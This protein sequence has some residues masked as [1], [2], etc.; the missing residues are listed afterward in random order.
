MMESLLVENE[1][2]WAR[3]WYEVREDAC[4]SME[5]IIGRTAFEEIL[6]PNRFVAVVG[7]RPGRFPLPMDL[8]DLF[9]D[10]E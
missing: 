8:S 4:W 9:E 10:A 5:Q 1:L 3:L 7:E 6:I 2:I